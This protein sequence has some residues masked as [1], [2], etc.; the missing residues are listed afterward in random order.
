MRIENLMWNLIKLIKFG[1][2][3]YQQF[4]NCA[5]RVHHATQS[6][7]SSLTLINLSSIKIIS[8]IILQLIEIFSSIP[9]S[10]VY[11]SFICHTAFLRVNYFLTIVQG[12]D[13]DFVNDI[14]KNH[15]FPIERGERKMEMRGWKQVKNFSF[16]QMTLPFFIYCHSSTFSSLQL[17]RPIHSSPLTF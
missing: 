9:W 14:M 5:I 13:N 11:A 2:I 1:K 8:K 17:F 15:F 7:F 16:Q 6:K 10:F 3:F 4:S 12:S